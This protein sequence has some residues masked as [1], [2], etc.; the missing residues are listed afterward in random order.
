VIL[1]DLSLALF[2]PSFEGGGAERAMVIL[3]KGFARRGVRVSFVLPK[4]VGPHLAQAREIAR[5]VDFGTRKVSRSIPSL[6]RYLRTEHPD[7]LIAALEHANTAALI[8]RRLSRASTP[9]VVTTHTMVSLWM[10]LR[11]NLKSQALLHLMRL[12][13]PTADAI[14]AV[15]RAAA[16]DL[17]QFVRLPRRRIRVIYN[18]VPIDEVVSLSSHRVE[19]SWLQPGEPPVVLAVG[20]LWPYKDHKTLIDAFAIALQEKPIR[21]VILGEGPERHKLED[22]IRRMGLED[23]VALPGFVD[24]PFSWMAKSSVF[25]LPSR[26]EG[27]SLALVEAMACGVT[28]VVTECPGG[29]IEVLENGKYGSV[30]PTGDAP[31]M[32]DA[33]LRS[34]DAPADPIQLRRRADDFSVE[35]AVSEYLELLNPLV[36]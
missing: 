17:S 28:P 10:S 11:K 25:V 32:A 4:A 29:P 16:S 15:S 22:Q 5:V 6:S 13:Y 1:L 2:L 26:W 30:T 3:A 33:I 34:I 27:M 24:N 7:A 19:S 9:V 31:A 36:T 12:V 18:P 23:D 14:V 8:A 21:L 20:S 35:R